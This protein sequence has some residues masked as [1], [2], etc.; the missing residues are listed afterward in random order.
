MFT[1]HGR[2]LI[3]GQVWQANDPRRLD[4]IRLLKVGARKVVARHL[5]SNRVTILKSS[6]FTVGPKGWSLLACV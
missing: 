6:A 5:I 2:F 1:K 4:A 3:E